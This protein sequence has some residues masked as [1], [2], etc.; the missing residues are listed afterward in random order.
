MNEVKLANIALKILFDYR[1][2]AERYIKET[3]EFIE[4][5]LESLNNW[6]EEKRKEIYKIVGWNYHA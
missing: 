6:Y 2:V 5:D 1:T 4:L 3:S